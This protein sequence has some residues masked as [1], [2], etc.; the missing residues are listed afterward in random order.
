VKTA[1]LSTVQLL[2]LGFLA[3]AWLSLITILAVAPQVYDQSLRLASDASARPGELLFVS[4]LTAFILLVAFGV[5]RRWR[6]IFWLVLVAFLSGVLRV[7]TSILQLAGWMPATGPSW[8]EV[9][10]AL[11]GVVQFAIGLVMLIDYR[12]YGVWGRPRDAAE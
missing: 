8:Y 6:W 9:F 12:R 11:I 5:V 10:Q 1:E 7:P 3:L 2:V 4:A